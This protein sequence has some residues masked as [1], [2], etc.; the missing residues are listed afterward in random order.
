MEHIQPVFQRLSREAATEPLKE[1]TRYIQFTWID[2][3]WCHPRRW[4]VFQQATRTNNDLEGWHRRLNVKAKKGNLSF[5]TMIHL[6]PQETEMVNV[7]VRLLTQGVVL[8]NH[9]KK[10]QKNAHQAV[11]ILVKVHWWWTLD[12]PTT[13]VVFTFEWTLLSGEHISID[14]TLYIS[15]IF[16]IY[17]IYIYTYMYAVIVIND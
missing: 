4:S 17:F 13:E 1:L 6:L 10:I 8:R 16:H 14:H 5:Y 2:S 12:I 15:C 11:T 9:R 3:S 7:Q